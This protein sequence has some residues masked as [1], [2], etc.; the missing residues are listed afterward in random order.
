MV[1]L[2]WLELCWKT[3]PLIFESGNDHPWPFHTTSLRHIAK[4]QPG[5]REC[6]WH[7]IFLDW[8]ENQKN[9][10]KFFPAK[11]A[12]QA[13][14]VGERECVRRF[15]P[16]KRAK[17]R[18]PKDNVTGLRKHHQPVHYIGIFRP[19]IYRWHDM[20]FEK[21][22]QITIIPKPELSGFLGDSLTKPPFGVTNRRFG[23]YNLPRKMK[24]IF[25]HWNCS[26]ALPQKKKHHPQI[27]NHGNLP[28]CQHPTLK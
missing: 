19:L 6:T 3:C 4:W 5:W 15:F 7:G 26:R 24:G 27:L 2:W 10:E 28:Q 17:H 16:L 9:T 18:L 8:N 12:L 22:G 11:N 23:C 1:V 14:L 13:I 25:N 20:G 21:S